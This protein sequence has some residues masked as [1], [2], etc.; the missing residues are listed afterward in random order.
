MGASPWEVG[1]NEAVVA[2]VRHGQTAWNA[3]RRFLG[4][5]DLP[6]DAVGR[7][8]AAALGASCPVRFSRVVCS[9]LSRARQTAQALGDEL[10]EEP[11]LIEQAQGELE[12]L[13][14]AEITAR[15]ATFWATWLAAS[16]DTPPPGGES[17]ADVRARALPAVLDHARAARPGAPVALVTHQMVIASVTCA[18]AGDPADGWRAFGVGNAAVTWLAWDGDRLRVRQSGWRSVEVIAADAPADAPQAR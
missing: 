1:E 8:Q 12:G 17:L 11:R 2:L 18:L 10:I 15:Y 7:R 9:P 3:E 4:R 5:V 6:L 13:A 16:V 14:L